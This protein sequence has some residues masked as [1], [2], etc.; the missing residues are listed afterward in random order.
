M[1]NQLEAGVRELVADFIKSGGTCPSK[2]SI[3]DRRKGYIDSAILAGISPEMA[4]EYVDELSGIQ[5]KIFKPTTENNLPI[6]IYFHGGC[7]VS[8]G[9]E[10]HEHQL[11]QLAKYSHNV[12]VCI[13]YRL[14]PEH[15][16]PAAHDDVYN[17][18]LAIKDL[19]SKYGGDTKNI[20]FVGDS[21]GAQLALITSLR[22]KNYQ[23]W[24]PRKQI[25]IYPM[26]DPAGQS[27][28]YKSN[29][30]DYIV[31]ANM[32]LSGFSLY[33]GNEDQDKSNPELYPLTQ[34]DFRG[35]P[36]TYIITAEFDPLR[37]EGETLYKKLISQGVETFCE[38]YLGVIH[39]FYQLSGVSKSAMRCIKHIAEELKV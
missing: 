1:I 10:T 21:A 9:F 32:L 30:T 31:T 16:Y 29:G 14:A 5:L 34:A 39:G 8:G 27:G 33:I 24:M 17:A 2:Q 23:H 6:T 22:L 11:R 12:V 26:L 15:T 35:L 7:F 3:T 20:S 18:V 38:R 28:S 4:E 19:G 36:P 25:L 13:K 37:D